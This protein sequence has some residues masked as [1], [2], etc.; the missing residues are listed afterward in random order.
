MGLRVPT[1]HAPASLDPEVAPNGTTPTASYMRR[2]ADGMN[3][4]ATNHKK[5]VQLKCQRFSTLSLTASQPW[6]FYFR[7]GENT[8]SL[9][10][11]MGVVD[12]TSAG[13][14]PTVTFTVYNATTGASV[15]AESFHYNGKNGPTIGQP[16]QVLNRTSL[17]TLRLEGLEADTEYY[18]IT[19][20]ANGFSLVYLLAVEGADLHADDEVTGVVDPTKFISDGPIYDEHIRDVLDAGDK[21]W[22]HGG[23][24]YLTWNHPTA[25]SGSVFATTYT[26][27]DDG[28]TA[29]AAT[30]LGYTLAASYHGH[31]TTAA[32]GPGVKIAVKAIRTA[33]AGSLSVRLYD[34]TNAIEIT[35]ITTGGVGD[36]YTTTQTIPQTT[37]KWDV[38]AKVSA[39]GTTFDLYAVCVFAYDGGENGDAAFELAAEAGEWQWVDVA[40]ESVLSQRYAIHLLPLSTGSYAGGALG[41]G[42]STSGGYDFN[43]GAAYRS[44]NGAPTGAETA[45]RIYDRTTGDWIT[46]G[47]LGTARS[48]AGACVLADGRILVS[49]GISSGGALLATAEIYDPVAGTW[50]A[51]GS[52]VRA[53]AGH[54]LTLLANGKVL[55][56][57]GRCTSG[58]T[59][60]SELWD[61]GTWG[62]AAAMPT[63]SG[64][65]VD[66]IDHDAFLCDSDTKVV[67]INGHCS[68]GSPTYGRIFIYSVAGNSWTEGTISPT[69]ASCMGVALLP[70]GKILAFGGNAGEYWAQGTD[71]THTRI[72]NPTTNAWSTGAELDVSASGQP[73]SLAMA[74][75]LDSGHVLR[76]FDYSGGSQSWL[77]NEDTDSWSAMMPT[78]ELYDTENE[79]EGAQHAGSYS[80][81]G[82]MG[83]NWCKLTDGS[84]L[85]Y[86]TESV[87]AE[88]F[89][90]SDVEGVGGSAPIADPEDM[91]LGAVTYYY[92]GT[93]WDA[94]LA[95]GPTKVGIVI[96]NPASGPGYLATHLSPAGATFLDYQAQLADAVAAGIPIRAVYVTS[97]YRDR[98][99]VQSDGI[100]RDAANVS[101]VT[102]E[103]DTYVARYGVGASGITAVFCDEMSTLGDAT[104][105]SYY[106]TI[107]THCDSLGLLLIQNPG[108][109]FPES[110]AQN[111][112]ADIYM[113]FENSAS[114]YAS[115]T[116]KAWM[117]NYP[118]S[119]FFH[120]IYNCPAG[121]YEA[122]VD[123]ARTKNVKYV[124]ITD[125]VMS[126]PYDVNPTYLT[127]LATY[128]DEGNP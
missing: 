64:T 2:A 47:S 87:G 59:S 26:N 33:G 95:L 127:G 60:E 69:P 84:V 34:G 39:G 85:I 25:N 12:T 88:L 75:K 102:D 20:V 119:L 15:D 45:C 44:P 22:R 108:S 101:N 90:P 97:N 63:V 125:D 100:A 23:C 118:P 68:H 10:I 57:G 17:I 11:W 36:W 19:G 71:Y 96:L 51:T 107:K 16:H 50:S 32:A 117:A 52:M 80:N 91:L 77:Y 30:S 43:T 55:A 37:T 79:F 109:S 21:H 31:A 70:S 124:W 116:P 38:Q 93:K 27:V 121:S 46:T 103:I 13:T 81:G 7:T 115:H 53:R 76:A 9:R 74:I 82:R 56:T 5:V 94:V 123:S 61:A 28:T 111:N 8:N 106:G 41:F 62:S 113:S 48:W 29:V 73:V 78:V 126:N 99:G 66:V 40:T 92:P 98:F 58:A 6:P 86:D 18:C 49:G 1:T 114:A 67:V 54:T 35:G 4:I 112:L 110:Y 105:L 42:G 89:V 65:V 83:R 72:Y 3:S 128:I 122:T 24:H 120:A 104:D 14:D